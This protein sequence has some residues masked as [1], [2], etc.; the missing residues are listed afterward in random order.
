MYEDLIDLAGSIAALDKKKPKQAHLRRAVSTAYYA[1]FH[2]LVDE[3]C[4][5]QIGTHHSQKEHRHALGV[6]G[7][8][9]PRGT[10]HQALDADQVTD[11]EQ[12]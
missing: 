2:Y 9:A 4:C 3:A 7:Q 8:L 12:L 6:Y 1:V 11:V 5:A 10:P